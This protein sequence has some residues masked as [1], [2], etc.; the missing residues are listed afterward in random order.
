MIP[1]IGFFE[2][3]DA[4]RK[5]PQHLLW[6]TCNPYKFS[7]KDYEH[8]LSLKMGQAL[9]GSTLPQ[10]IAK[11]VTLTERSRE[12]FLNLYAEKSDRIPT[13]PI[14]A[15]LPAPLLLKNLQ[16]NI[17]K[18]ILIALKTNWSVES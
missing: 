5:Y 17:F 16:K 18:L 1:S 11:R 13:L 9:Y 4:Q 7:I 10:R 15:G 12:I 2:P 6:I 8:D 3:F 14:D